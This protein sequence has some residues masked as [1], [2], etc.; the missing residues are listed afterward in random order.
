MNAMNTM[1]ANVCACT[2]KP[3]YECLMEASPH[4]T[5]SAQKPATT[6]GNDTAR[7]GIKS[8]TI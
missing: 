3:I 1:N 8:R 6:T 4:R 5:R 2:C 7:H